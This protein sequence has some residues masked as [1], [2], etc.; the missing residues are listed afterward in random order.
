MDL[1]SASPLG[2]KGRGSHPVLGSGLKQ[3]DGQ[4]GEMQFCSRFKTFVNNHLLDPDFFLGGRRMNFH[5]TIGFLASLLLVLG[6]GVPD[7][8][9]Q[10]VRVSS[11]T[12]ARV[13][14]NQPRTVTVTVELSEAPGAN[15]TVS[16]QLALPSTLPDG[17]A[18]TLSRPDPSDPTAT[19]TTFAPILISGTAKTG[20]STAVTVTVTDNDEYNHPRDKTVALDLTATNAGGSPP[21]YTHLDDAAEDDDN[22]NV[23]LTV[24]EDDQP[25]GALSLSS[26]PPALSVGGSGGSTLTVTVKDAPGNDDQDPPVAIT[27][28][29]S[30]TTEHS[31]TT[32]S[33]SGGSASETTI[34]GT[35]KFAT[36][37]FTG[38]TV[39]AAQAGESVTIT[40]NAVNYTPGTVTLAI[41]DRSADDIEG[42]RVTI[43][44]PASD[45]A[46]V[47]YGANKVKVHVTR[48]NAIAYSW[49]TFESV[50]VALRDTHMVAD[51]GTDTALGNIV[52]LTASGFGVDDDEV[53]FSTAALLGV[54]TI[55][56]DPAPATIYKDKSIAYDKA[57]D[58]LI[59]SFALPNLSGTD[60]PVDSLGT[61]T[62]PSTARAG[63]TEQGR[64]MG[65]FARATFTDGDGTVLMLNSNDDETDVFTSPSALAS[66]PEADRVVGDGKLLK[67]DL[68]A[69]TNTVVTGL[70]TTV[71]GN[72]TRL[73]GHNGHDFTVEAGIG[74]EIKVAVGIG[75]QVRYRDEGV[76]IQIAA[77]KN[78]DASA[79]ANNATLKTANFS[80]LQVIGA[81][82]DSLR[83]SL[84]LTEG[85]IKTKAVAD[86]NNRDGGEIK[87]NATFEPDYINIRV[88]ARSK[89]QAANW[90]G[91][92]QH[93]FK[94]DTR[95]PG[96]IVLHPA[97]GGRFTGAHADVD[98]EEHLNPL[99]LRVDEVIESL[100]VYAKGAYS[101]ADDED[102]DTDVSIIRLWEAEN[103][104]LDRS[105][106]I[107]ASGDAVGDTIAYSTLDLKWRNAKGALKET[108]DGGTKIDLVI[109]ATDLAGNTTTKTLAGV[110]HDQV[111]P[112]ITQYFPRNDLLVDVDNQI[113]DATRHPVFT[114]PEAVDSVSIVY[115]PSLGDDIVR[116]V[117]VPDGGLPKGEHQEII[118]NPFEPNRTYTLT[119]FARDLAGNAFETPAGDA[120]D[121]KFDEDFKN[122]IAN[123]FKVTYAESD[124]VIAGQINDI[125]IQAYDNKGT[126]D[127]DS[128]DHKAVTHKGPAMISA[129]DM[130]S[131]GVASS[132]RYVETNGV[133]DN[134]DGT[135]MLDKD[136]WKLGKR[137]VQVMSDKAIGLTKL[138]VQNMMAG[139]GGTQVP[140]FEGAVDSFYVGAA[141]FVK[142]ELTAWQD[143]KDVSER[144]ITDNFDL[145]VRPVDNYGN[146]SVRAYTGATG[147][148]SEEDSL[149]ILDTRVKDEGIEYKQGIDVTFASIPA[150]EE[151]N[152]LF[153]FP[154]ERNG[155][156]FP[157]LL[158]ANRRS[159]T[160]QARVDNDN[161][162][163]DPADERSMNIRSPAFFKII[164]PLMPELT[165]WVPGVEGDQAGND[166][167]I[168]AD[169][170]DITVTV[171]AEGYTT[172]G[173]MVTFT[174]DGTA[175]DPVAADDEGVARLMIT[176]S[177][178][179]SVTVSATDGNWPSDDLTITF[180][181]GPDEPMRMAYAD[182]N[183]DPVYLISME[184]MTVDV[185][186]FLAFVAAYGSS[187]GDENY[188]IQADVDDDGDVDID[189]FVAF[190]SSYERTAVGPATKPLVLAPGINENAEFLLS[191]GS[192][193]VVAG[194]LVA[195]DVSLADVQALVGYGFALNYETDKFEF[196]SVA[197]ADEDLLKSTGGET[198]F[199]HVV[200]DGQITVANGLYNGTAVSG[201]GD[202]VRFV[203]RVLREFEDNARFEIANGLVFD[204]S[205]LQ[206]PAVVAGVLELQSTPR[207]FAL[208]QNFPN[209][210]NPDTTI[211]YDLAESAD[212]TLQIYNVLGQVVRTLVASEA[213]NAGRYQ[214]RWNGMD[215]RG[216]PVS[217]GI[218]FYQISADGKFSDVRKLMLL[219]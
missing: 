9:A 179:G 24:R 91:W 58:R 137:T 71:E 80:Q 174:K 164:M 171:A 50:A 131:G 29:V 138:L 112:E 181:E 31:G 89:D 61:L 62:D 178:A 214:I 160:I 41:V 39:D 217:S 98:F 96:I 14:E 166:V 218:Y 92:I 97:D 78:T 145:L 46:W 156:T 16:I 134:G 200:A 111:V 47:G 151:L 191:L 26:N 17:V 187:D 94:G 141:D 102:A 148:K 37:T 11:L 85:Q 136:E 52:T 2:R 188:N 44:T 152:P 81:A 77:M 205:Q 201:G 79:N 211:K 27:V 49:T 73:E 53:V 121:L 204:P 32:G 5:K 155:T 30:F 93:D 84:E 63:D 114:L 115:D 172:A 43:A 65:V 128:D 129:W 125:T 192:E 7:S 40:A 33:P 86:G 51:L 12:P 95:K 109:E 146:A 176:M 132:V 57:N 147:K 212:V 182:A 169:P 83:T 54:E 66:V 19:L 118:P 1:R 68:I 126:A 105:E 144:G 122:P 189:D 194:E 153:V 70:V 113:N 38:A 143:G 34:T 206:N 162:S 104:D 60:S 103:I 219:K 35:A 130:A 25:I 165:L 159:L 75:N 87:K 8:F 45:G 177:A 198:L 124:S 163:T 48:L 210:F 90:S 209:P 20:T 161:L 175:M 203:F 180:V 10:T 36:S 185:A 107:A 120:A 208:H 196:V 64:R 167:V 82:G 199:H 13:Q 170:G 183:G 3:R 123:T 173:S 42:F 168:P 154:I 140:T 88:R 6:I 18:I 195:V 186:D 55:V 106:V 216:V 139:E 59:F 213:Q 21:T 116:S 184:N 108:A 202:V 23:M 193:R 67:L 207:E 190:I 4:R 56:E 28:T 150:L 158:P 76:Q 74:D 101:K 22:N 100:S 127:D 133:A 157:I 119:I 69:P 110:F 99:Q 149:A 72:E 135:A 197:P 15:N 215:E 117:P 142:F